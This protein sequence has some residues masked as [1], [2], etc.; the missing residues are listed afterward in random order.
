M[1]E[2]INDFFNTEGRNLFH[3][4]YL[5]KPF[6]A[7][8]PKLRCISLNTFISMRAQHYVTTPIVEKL[9]KVQGFC[10]RDFQ[11]WDIQNKSTSIQ[12]QMV[13]EWKPNL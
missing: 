10:E 7:F 6:H 2:G 8:N 3:L 13:M 1:D 11:R 5:N 9:R 4:R 12:T